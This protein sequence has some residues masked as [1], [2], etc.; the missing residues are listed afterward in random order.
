MSNYFDLTTH[1]VSDVW[2]PFSVR[3][4]LIVLCVLSHM[5]NQIEAPCFV[6]SV[7]QMAPGRKQVQHFPTS[8]C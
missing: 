5:R 3:S 8:F 6:K 2:I 1:K 4:Q 7:G